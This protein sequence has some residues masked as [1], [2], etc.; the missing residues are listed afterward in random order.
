VWQLFR[1]PN[2]GTWFYFTLL[3]GWIG[4]AVLL[5]ALAGLIWLRRE[6]SWRERLLLIWIAVPVL[7]FTL[8]PVKG[9]QYLLPLSPA[10]AILAARTLSRPIPFRRV[11]VGRLAMGV[12]AAATALS[13]AIPAWARSQPSF[14]TNFLAGSGG[15]IGGREAGDW[16]LDHVPAGSRLLAIGPST[17]NVLEYYGHRPVSALS[18]S[19]N[20]RDRNPTYAPVLNPDLA[21]RDGVF[22]YVVWDAYTDAHSSFFAAEALRLAKKYHGVAVYTTASRVR[23]PVRHGAPEPAVVIYEVY[24]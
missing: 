2:H 7:F 1:R 24:P 4:P 10:L 11:A 20:P 19:T 23:D 9:F 3:P 15:M 13:L 14:S 18:V 12:L 5:A 6:A 16:V 17:A 22:Q 21:V 8:W